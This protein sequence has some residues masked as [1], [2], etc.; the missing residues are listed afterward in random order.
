[1]D[2]RPR[3]Y[4]WIIDL[5]GMLAGAALAGHLVA[6]QLVRVLSPMDT[7]TGQPGPR[8][9]S[10]PIQP[11]STDSSERVGAQSYE[12]S[13]ALV[14]QVFQSVG[15]RPHGILIVPATAH[16]QPVGVRVFG[17]SGLLE[18]IGLRSGDLVLEANGLPLTR[19]DAMLAAYAAVRQASKASLVIQRDGRH[20]LWT[21]TIGESPRAQSR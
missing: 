14:D 9:A 10:R 17:G 4:V 1:M 16:G 15:S 2:A 8:R 13:H 18:A 19:P 5:I 11:A 7:Q 20:I 3:R 12:I 21:Y 6:N